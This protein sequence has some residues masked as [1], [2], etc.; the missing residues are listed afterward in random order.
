MPGSW[1][2]FREFSAQ[3]AWKASTWSGFTWI[4]TWTISMGGLALLGEFEEDDARR[5]ADRGVVPGE[6]EAAGLAIHPEDGDVVAALV[7]AIEEAAGGVEGKATGV[8][9]PR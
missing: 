6:L 4:W 2:L 1:R 9:P 5:I 7:A 3:A 8:I